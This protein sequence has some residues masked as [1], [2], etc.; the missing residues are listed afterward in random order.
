MEAQES[1][2]PRDTASTSRAQGARS[3]LQNSKPAPAYQCIGSD[4]TQATFQPD[5]VTNL[6]FQNCTS[7]FLSNTLTLTQEPQD[8]YVAGD[9]ISVSGQIV[10]NT[11]PM[12]DVAYFDGS[13]EYVISGDQ[14]TALK[15]P[16][17]LAT[18][19]WQ[20]SSGVLQMF[21]PSSTGTSSPNV[22]VNDFTYPAGSFNLLDFQVCTASIV[23]TTLV[24]TPTQNVYSAGSGLTLSF[25]SLSN[26]SPAPAI[27]IG[28]ETF[29]PTQITTVAYDSGFRTRP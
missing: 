6:V 29:G 26:A 4:G 14:I 10:T 20:P 5:T 9:G 2:S 8:P 23:G 25:G 18:Y 15:L 19:S 28:G 11:K 24:I 7:S 13:T 16:Q 1:T 27:Q 3:R 22:R 17:E 21:L 12:C